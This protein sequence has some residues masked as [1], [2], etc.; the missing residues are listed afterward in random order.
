MVS[1]KELLYAA[2]QDQPRCPPLFLLAWQALSPCDPLPRG[3]EDRQRPS[4]KQVWWRSLLRAGPEHDK[5][6]WC[7]PKC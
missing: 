5:G 4:R 1:N 6:M 3:R 7:C 2:L